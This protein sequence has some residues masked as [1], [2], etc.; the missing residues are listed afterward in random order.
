M[1]ELTKKIIKAA[2]EIEAIDRKKEEL[3]AQKQRLIAWLDGLTG[4]K[5]LSEP[6]I[7][8][9]VEKADGVQYILSTL[10]GFKPSTYTTELA[11]LID[12]AS[13]GDVLEYS[14]VYELLGV[15][16]HEGKK[17]TVRHSMHAL[18]RAG[19]VRQGESRGSYVVQKPPRPNAYSVRKFKREP[20][21]S[22]K[23]V[24]KSRAAKARSKKPGVEKPSVGFSS[25][26]PETEIQVSLRDMF[27][28]LGSEQVST[29]EVYDYLGVEDNAERARIRAN[30]TRM[31]GLGLIDKPSRGVYRVA[32]ESINLRGQILEC[33]KAGRMKNFAPAN[34]IE[35]LNVPKEKRD[36]VRSETW[37]MY[38][39]GIFTRNDDGLYNLP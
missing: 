29:Q 7:S 20:M 28:E 9:T 13:D 24:E 39:A 32:F 35:A 18:H 2:S 26:K 21:S 12:R 16:H 25:W 34:V 4:G 10:E 30:L 11:L 36:S 22:R 17:A 15:L 31:V 38:K 19:W 23:G 5:I 27:M 14:N 8:D 6:P 33:V 3:E 37:K 1:M